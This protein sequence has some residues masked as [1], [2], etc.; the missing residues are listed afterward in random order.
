VPQSGFTSSRRVLHNPLGI[1]NIV[2]ELPKPSTVKGSIAVLRAFD[3]EPRFLR[4]SLASNST[5][6]MI[7]AIKGGMG[8]PHLFQWD[9][10]RLPIDL[11]PLDEQRRIAHFLD[12]E[13]ARID[14]MQVLRLD[15]MQVMKERFNSVWSALIEGAGRL[16]GW[17][18]LRRL[19]TAITDG[20]FG[21]SLASDH[22]SDSGAR[23]VRL[24]NI[25][26]ARFR[27]DDVAYIPE[28]YYQELRRHEV[29]EGDL[30]VA[31]LGDENHPIGRA[32]VAPS[33]LGHAIVKA[34][35][36]R[37]R[38]DRHRISHDYA[39]WALSSTSVSSRVAEMSRGSTRS[40]INLSVAKGIAIPVPPLPEQQRLVASLTD[41]RKAVDA[42]SAVCN[43]QSA[44][45]AERRQALITAAVTG[46]MDVT[47]ARGGVG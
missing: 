26:Q 3:I 24:G 43:L 30:I 20:P 12:V 29:R 44:L 5:Q 28:S 22:Y 37:L 42:A 45:L 15:Q 1:T 27:D 18:P 35:C 32:C 31:G 8:V 40:R 17:L 11:P 39:A 19:V 25:G 34:D 14:R 2:R 13:T 4:Y 41:Q 47:T 21:S 36:F 33:G 46:Q 9:I 16:N 6:S 10:K 7:D 38:L 23:V